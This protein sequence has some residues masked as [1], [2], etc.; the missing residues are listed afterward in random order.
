[1]R[2]KDLPIDR[3]R[4]AVYTKN[5][6][7]CVLRLLRRYYDDQTSEQ[8]WERIQ[9]Q[10]CEFLKDEPPMAGAKIKVSIYD[11]ILIF[12]WYRHI[13]EEQD[14]M[15]LGAM[16]CHSDVI[17]FGNLP[18]TDFRRTGTLCQGAD[19]CDFDFVRYKTDAG[20][21]WERTKSIPF[22]AGIAARIA[23]FL[24]QAVIYPSGSV[25]LFPRN[26]TVCFHPLIDV[27]NIRSKNRVIFRC[28]VGKRIPAPIFL[29]C[30][31]LYRS[32][33][34]LRAPDNFSQA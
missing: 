3:T 18:Y 22:H 12:A 9:L 28:H 32:K 4:H 26:L 7:K 23:F 29:V 17:N 27:R 34:M 8:L 2:E 11:P 10:Y 31:F 1:M 6:K 16:F 19:C 13:F 25:P 15:K 24:T 33:G 21:G 14:C 30:V 5:A 20:D